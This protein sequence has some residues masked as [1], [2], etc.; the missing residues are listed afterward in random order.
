MI[1]WMLLA[2]YLAFLARIILGLNRLPAL[3]K[4]AKNAQKSFT[5]IIAAHNEEAHIGA[6]LEGLV[7]QNYPPDKIEII[8]AAD[9]CTDNTIPIIRSFQSSFTH[10]KFIEIDD[11]PAGV[12]P[13]K[14]ALEMAIEQATHP[15]FL[16]LDADVTIKVEFFAAYNQQFSDDTAAVVSLMRFTPPTNI[17]ERF[18]I[19]E[20]MVSW[21]I[22]GAGIGFQKPIIS[23]GGNWGYT[24]KAYEGVAGFAEIRKSLSGD[25]DLLLQRFSTQNLP[26]RMCLDPNGWVETRQVDSFS[27]FLRQRRRHFSAGKYYR[28]SLKLGYLL[29]HGTHLGLWVW[30]MAAGGSWLPLLIKLAADIW[31]TRR[32]NRL[33]QT[34]IKTA[35]TM[36]FSFLYM[37][38]N[39]F[40]GPLAHLGR[41]KW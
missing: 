20:K 33:F 4:T 28:N 6:L 5:V 17:L 40:V 26:V 36:L 41:L 3:A 2:I 8:I 38:Y 12:S 7:A 34:H 21:M 24:K 11:V 16:F 19:F 32:G 9:R 29:F 22:A 35:E 14:H 15:I 37:L 13:K 30:P 31:V 23:Y 27:T 10:L 18:L 25:D 39:T 1:G